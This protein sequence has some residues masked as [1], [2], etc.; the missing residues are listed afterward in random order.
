[1]APYSTLSYGQMW[2]YHPA[3]APDKMILG[4]TPDGYFIYGFRVIA[5]A[6]IMPFTF[7]SR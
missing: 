4:L 3:R 5:L 7:T 2:K 1:M 6:V